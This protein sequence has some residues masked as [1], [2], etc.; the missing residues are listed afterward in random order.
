VR[1]G[2][3]TIYVPPVEGKG[4]GIIAKC[5]T[6]RLRSSYD[7]GLSP[8]DN[9]RAAATRLRMMLGPS[10]KGESPRIESAYLKPGIYI[11]IIKS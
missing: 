6:H 5:D 2:I 7:Y 11:H 9:H 10:P 4:A 1:I 8:E 3:K